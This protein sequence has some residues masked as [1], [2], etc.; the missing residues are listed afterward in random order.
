MSIQCGT[1]TAVITD[2]TLL[3]FCPSFEPSLDDT[4]LAHK[5][6]SWDLTRV[7]RYLV[8][9]GVIIPDDIEDLEREYKRF[10]FLSCSTRHTVPISRRVDEMWHAHILFTQD[11][12]KFGHTLGGYIHHCPAVEDSERQQLAKAYD[13]TLSLYS[14]Y[15]GAPSPQWWPPASQVCLGADGEGGCSNQCSKED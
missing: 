15:F 10:L 1:A 6:E 4:A 7:K 2:G 8:K 13:A 14:R 5:I 9:R 11:Y 3:A 12:V